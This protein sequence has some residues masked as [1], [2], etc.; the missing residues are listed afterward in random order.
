[1]AGEVASRGYNTSNRLGRAFDTVFSKQGV[2]E[3]S[4]DA[5]EKM[6]T[7]TPKAY[8]PTFEG[9][10]I[11][12][13]EKQFEKEL[14]THSQAVQ[15]AQKK[16]ADANN[17]ILQIEAR[18]QTNSNIYAGN[19]L[20]AETR[21]AHDALQQAQKDLVQAQGK[22]GETL[23]ILRQAQADKASGVKGAIW[24]PRIQEM[25]SDDVIQKGIKK[26]LWIAKKEALANGEKFNPT[27]Y[28]ITGMDEHGEPIVSKVPNMRMLDAGK[29]GL[30]SIINENKNPLTGKMNETGRAVSMLKNSYVKEIDALNPDYARARQSYGDQA[31][32]LEALNEGRNFLKMDKEEISRFM[33]DQN[34]S[35][36][37]KVAFS[38]GVRR[39]LQDMLDKDTGNP[40]KSIWRTGIKD[41]LEPLFPNK[42]TFDRFSKVMEHEQSMHRINGALATGSHTNL[43]KNFQAQTKNPVKIVKGMMNPVGAASDMGMDMISNSMAKKAAG[44]NKEQAAIVG[45][46]LTT[47]DPQLWY[48]LANRIKQ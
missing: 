33:K 12:P 8:K 44:M 42:E 13:L 29:K 22:H 15:T 21:Q 41:K 6:A 31:A 30:D 23:D 16:V 43:L 25:L 18:K 34:I 9:G 32:R 19:N 5:L 27:E 45:R 26:G 36:A 46:Y 11:A 38:V 47:N 10:S 7:E 14:G 28:G 17:R 24:S 37:E 3:V 40:I 1:M 4:D 20:T 35:K 39:E 48:D 2:Y